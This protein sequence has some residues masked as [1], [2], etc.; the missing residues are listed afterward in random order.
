MET[1]KFHMEAASRMDWWLDAVKTLVIRN[2]REK[3]KA[4]GL[5]VVGIRTQM[6]VVKTPF[7]KM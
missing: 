6:M 4:Q 5:F 7:E 1:L 3:V 2:T